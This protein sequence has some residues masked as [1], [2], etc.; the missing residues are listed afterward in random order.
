MWRRKE[1]HIFRFIWTF[2]FSGEKN[3]ISNKGQIITMVNPRIEQ[4][5]CQTLI[6]G[7]IYTH[8]SFPVPAQ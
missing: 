3:L 7:F 4:T 1:T 8:T 6:N 2:A 5:V